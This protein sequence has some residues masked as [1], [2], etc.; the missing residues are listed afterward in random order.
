MKRVIIAAVLI[1]AVVAP[2]FGK[3]LLAKGESNTA[4]GRYSIEELSEPILLAGKEMKAYSITY[5]KTGTEIKIAVDRK[6]NETVYYV[7]SP[8]FSVKYV[9][10]RKYFG[11]GM[12]GK[13]LEKEGYVTKNEKM[14]MHQ[15]FHQKVMADATRTPT[16]YL[17]LIASYFPLLCCETK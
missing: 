5:D 13:E 7:L 11:I 9:N 10:N 4:Y 8:E 16:D 2:S 12:T 6:R 14:N 17:E 3:R 15:Y 1:F